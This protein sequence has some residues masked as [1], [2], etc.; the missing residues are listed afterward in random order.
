MIGAKASRPAPDAVNEAFWQA[1]HGGQRQAAE[2][3]LACGADPNRVPEWTKETPLDIAQS[4]NANNLV[5]WL[6]GQG[7]KSAKELS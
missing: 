3:L 7:A 5:E 2:Y 4:Q 1:C 6:R